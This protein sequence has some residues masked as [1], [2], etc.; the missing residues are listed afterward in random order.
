MASTSRPP[1]VADIAARSGVSKATVSHA[2]N[3]SGRVNPN[4]RERV[5]QVAAEL[6]YSANVHARNLATGR[7]MTVALQVSGPAGRLLVPDSAYY[8]E[9][10]NSAAA[11]ALARGY[12]PMLTPT[13]ISA[14]AADA[15]AVDGALIIDPGRNDVLFSTLRARGRRVVTTGRPMQAAGDASWVDNDHVTLTRLVLDHF[16]ASGY[17]R[18]ALLTTSSSHSYAQDLVR[19]YRAWIAEHDTPE[20]L[21]QM[22]GT[23]TAERAIAGAADLLSRRPRPD[24]IYATF[25]I[26]ALGALRAATAAGLRVPEDLGIASTVDSEA[27]RSVAPTI[28]ACRLHSTRIGQLAMD[29]LADELEG[30]QAPRRVLVP[31][32]IAARASTA[33]SGA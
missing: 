26:F 9:V 21:V 31:A 15:L 5:L 1:T 7:H 30:A 12:V 28:T 6:G 32:E 27:M 13:S 20:L 25:D 2:L 11:T 24:A 17:E 23:P 8:I 4:T 22:R 18:P 3:G 19:G 16:V 14:P 29:L 10:L 33:R